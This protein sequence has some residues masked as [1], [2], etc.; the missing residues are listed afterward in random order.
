MDYK[1][2]GR[3]RVIKNQGRWETLNGEGEEVRGAN[4]E[5]EGKADK[6]ADT[7]EGEAMLDRNKFHT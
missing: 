2:R 7:Q 5:K 4:V 3:H 6:D 1:D